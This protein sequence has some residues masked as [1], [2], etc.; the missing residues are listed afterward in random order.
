MF[1]SPRQEALLV[2]LETLPHSVKKT[3]LQI[4]SFGKIHYAADSILMV[5]RRLSDVCA[6]GDGCP[7][8]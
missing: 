8:S 6:G 7:F 2:Y 5:S 3:L 4:H 1:T